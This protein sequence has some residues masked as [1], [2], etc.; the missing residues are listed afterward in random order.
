MRASQKLALL[1]RIASN[2]EHRYEWPDILRYLGHYNVRTEDPGE[3]RSPIEYVKAHLHHS[4]PNILVEI[5][6]DLELEL[7]AGRRESLV[8]PKNWPDDKTFRL[9][10]SHLSKDK[11]HA[12]RL[13]DCLVPHHVSAFVAHQDIQPTLEWQREIERALNVMDAFL[14]IHTSGFSQSVWTQQE[15]GFAVA[16]GVKIV[17][18]K[19]DEDP[20]GFISRQ[21]ALPRLNKNAEDVAKE[22]RALLF[23]DP[24]TKEHFASVTLSKKPKVDD[25]IP[26]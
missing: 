19:F 18:L 4:P 12:T 21:Q 3:Y 1:D 10:I 20:T 6:E 22:I 2:L 7:P 24:L 5:A 25:E 8:P 9:F 11:R 16:R 17:S 14:C 13:R 15:I 23:A 26:F